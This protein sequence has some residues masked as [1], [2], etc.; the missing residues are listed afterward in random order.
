[1]RYDGKFGAEV[2]Q[3]GGKNGKIVVHPK[4]RGDSFYKKYRLAKDGDPWAAYDI[5]IIKLPKRVK[6]NKNSD[7]FGIPDG[8]EVVGTFV[9]PI[10]MPKPLQTKLSKK[11][12][13]NSS[14]EPRKNVIATGFG[15]EEDSE[16]CNRIGNKEICRAVFNENNQKQSKVLKEANLQIIS[17]NACNLILRDSW[18]KSKMKQFRIDKSQICATST[19]KKAFDTCP[20]DSGGPL[21]R[22]IKDKYELVGVTSWGFTCGQRLPGVYNRIEKYMDWIL[23][24]SDR[25][26]TVDGEVL[27]KSIK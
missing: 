25:L 6:F 5:G 13:Y 17:N 14:K 1:L 20:G 3:I 26:Q 16:E 2:V 21:V 27:A 8:R 19:S 9:R 11:R 15:L 23:K 18:A 4:Y 10:C 22:K 12:R 7:S 24:F